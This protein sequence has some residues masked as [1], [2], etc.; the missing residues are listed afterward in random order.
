MCSSERSGAT[1]DSIIIKH[2]A[3]ALEQGDAQHYDEWWCC[4]FDKYQA[5]LRRVANFIAKD[6]EAAEDCYVAATV[7]MQRWLRRDRNLPLKSEHH[8]VNTFS[9]F[10]RQAFCK[11][12]LA[13]VRRQDR[14]AAA[15]YQQADEA[16]HPPPIAP[17]HGFGDDVEGF[18][19]AGRGPEAAVLLGE[20]IQRVR[21]CMLRLSD[22]HRR[23]LIL[24]YFEGLTAEQ[25]AKL[26]KISVD[27]VRSRIH[28]GRLK[29]AEL[30]VQEGLAPG[31]PGLHGEPQ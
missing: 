20:R 24:M 11:Q 30:L 14:L 16:D 29:L 7:R 4:L 27:A 28:R 3:H 19:D 1:S 31:A 12:V 10:M 13:A 25:I 8:Y 23:V 2:L 6:P 5:R 17:A 18:P 22:D 15:G 9:L 26:L 21:Q